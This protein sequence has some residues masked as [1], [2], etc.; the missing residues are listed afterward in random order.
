MMRFLCV[1]CL[2]FLLA[3]PVFAQPAPVPPTAVQ[4]KNGTARLVADMATRTQ[5]PFQTL[6]P[7]TAGNLEIAVTV[8]PNGVPSDATLRSSTGPVAMNDIAVKHVRDVWRWQ[9][10]GCAHA[11]VAVVRMGFNARPPTDPAIAAMAVD[12]VHFLHADAAAHPAALSAERAVVFMAVSLRPDGSLRFHHV[13]TMVGA[14]RAEREEASRQIVQGRRWVPS[15]LD[16]APISSLTF[17]G[18][19]WTP[20][21]ETPVNIDALKAVLSKTGAG[22]AGP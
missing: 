20:P 10:T 12:A 3:G 15:M 18:V 21:G 22:L 14:A 11:I 7:G 17:F 4:C 5:P 2:A 19:I 8:E 6:P 16:G 1:A 13:R 9:P